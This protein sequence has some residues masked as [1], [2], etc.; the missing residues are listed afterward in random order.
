MRLFEGRHLVGGRSNN[1]YLIVPVSEAYARGLLTTLHITQLAE[2]G[3]THRGLVF[4]FFVSLFLFQ[5]DRYL[6]FSPTRRLRFLVL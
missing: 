2:P 4:Q 3:A 6:R 5:L 1:F